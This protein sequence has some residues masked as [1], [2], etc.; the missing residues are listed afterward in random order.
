LP[1]IFRAV[2]ISVSLIFSG[3]SAAAAQSFIQVQSHATIRDTKQSAQAFARDFAQTKAFLTKSGWYAIVIGPMPPDAAL[4][5]LRDLTASGQIPGDSFISS[6]DSHLSQLWPINVA[7]TGSA[8]DTVAAEET[9]VIIRDSDLKASKRVEKGWSRAYK[10]RLQRYMT[11]TGDYDKAIDGDYGRGTRAAIKSFQARNKFETTGYLTGDQ[12]ALMI[13]QYDAFFAR[14]GVKKV[15]DLDAGIEIDMPLALV[16]FERFSPPF[17][18]YGARGD[19]SLS[20]RLI[21]ATGG[22][23]ALRDLIEPLAVDHALP[24]DFLRQIKRDWFVISYADDRRATYIYVQHDNGLIKGFS[25]VWSPEKDGDLLSFA[26]SMRHSFVP[27]ADYYLDPTLSNSQPDIDRSALTSGLDID[28]PKHQGTGFLI[29]AAGVVLT[30][31]ANVRDC[32]RITTDAG[33]NMAVLARDPALKLAV[34]RPKRAYTPRSFALFA[35]DTPFTGA[36]IAVSGFSYPAEMEV[37]SLNFG[38][39]TGSATTPKRAGQVRLD[40]RVSPGDAG[41]PVLDNRGAVIGMQL[42]TQSG[43]TRP[44][45]VNFAAQADGITKLLDT[46]GITYGRIAAY[47][48]V[49]PE[50]IAAMA[51]DFTVKLSCWSP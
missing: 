25:M 11:W 5:A 42:M 1:K 30:H 23:D 29:S 26:Q 3:L 7:T 12:I 39:V 46:R 28:S 9:P 13:G 18:R 15:R 35:D 33:V 38:T 22:R 10:M 47:D 24:N 19:G 31:V 48:P 43:S 6:G 37:S 8:G 20:V 16:A 4:S 41:G 34:L 2:L 21:S 14:L 17:V 49:D 32:R 44:G 36:E 51:R 40:V 50:D 27:I 45:Y